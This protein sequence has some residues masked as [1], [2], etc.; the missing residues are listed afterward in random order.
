MNLHD[1]WIHL[2]ATLP[3]HLSIDEVRTPQHQM[4][5]LAINA[6]SGALVILSPDRFS[7]NIIDH[8][9]DRL[10][11]TQIVSEGINTDPELTKVYYIA[12]PLAEAIRNN[13]HAQL[14]KL[15]QTKSK[16]PSLHGVA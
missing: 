13:D 9:K 12:Q 3:E 16:N 15:L 10:T 14:I 11:E 1:Q 6:E 4:S 5:F 8:L 2:K 7:K